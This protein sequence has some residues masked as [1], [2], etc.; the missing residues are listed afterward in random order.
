M[1]KLHFCLLA[2][3][4]IKTVKLNSKD[5]VKGQQLACTCIIASVRLILSCDS[6]KSLMFGV[7]VPEK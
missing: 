3:F 1:V 6:S 4:F 2:I 5:C 7:L